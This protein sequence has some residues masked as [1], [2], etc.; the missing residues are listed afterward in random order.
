MNH[1]RNTTR[2]R[3]E[4]DCLPGSNEDTCRSGRQRGPSTQWRPSEALRLLAEEEAAAAETMAEA[5][6]AG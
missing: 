6:W 4:R 2:I 3:T 1:Q 5:G